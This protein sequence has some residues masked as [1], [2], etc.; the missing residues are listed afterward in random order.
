MMLTLQV[1]RRKLCPWLLPMPQVRHSPP[2][3]VFGPRGLEVYHQSTVDR[4]EHLYSVGIAL[5]ERA[6]AA[7]AECVELM[8]FDPESEDIEADM[9]R[10]I[11]LC[12]VPVAQVIENID[13]GRRSQHVVDI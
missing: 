5:R 6:E 3:L 7:Q 4:L 9:C 8:G 13:Q 11:V 1:L 10:D 12:G 2:P